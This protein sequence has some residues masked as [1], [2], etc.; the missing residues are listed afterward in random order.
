VEIALL[1]GLILLNGLFAMSEIALVTARRGRLQARAEAGDA[2]AIAAL[3][4]GENPTQ[5]GENPTQFMSTVQIGITSIGLLSGIA[6]EAA[7]ADPFASYLMAWGMTNEAAHYLAM[8][9]RTIWR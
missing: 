2:G 3:K 9:R 7:L 6:G 4:L 8:R 5:F 1:A